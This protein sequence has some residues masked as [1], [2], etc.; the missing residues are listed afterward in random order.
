MTARKQKPRKT[1]AR[2][3]LFAREYVT[4][5]N[6]ERSAV[7]AGYSQKSAA[8]KASQLLNKV[9]VQEIIAKLLAKREAKLDYSADRILEELSR[10]GFSNMMDFLAPETDAEG[11]VVVGGDLILDFSKLTREQAAAIQEYTV[12]ATGGTGD[13]ERKQVMRTRF[14][15]AD[16]TRALHLLGIYRKLFTEKI[17]V[18]GDAD[19]LAALALGR[20]RAR[21]R[22]GE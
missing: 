12:D 22:A 17:E 1:N 5:L 16:K 6:G 7:A 11:K 20:E 14:K 13:G 9:K 21:T 4:D 3:G 19:V 10:L 18:T 2:Y 15:L 8:S